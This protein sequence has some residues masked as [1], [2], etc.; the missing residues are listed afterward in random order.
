M[1]P[2]HAAAL[3]LAGLALLTL[4]TAGCT[5]RP[6]SSG[7]PSS[8]TATITPP[9]YATGA[10][11]SGG[12]SLG[13]PGGSSSSSAGKSTAGSARA[14]DLSAIDKQLGAMQSEIDTL[15]MPT[16]SD[17]NGAQSAVY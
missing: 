17:F 12:G 1:T 16:D 4:V 2:R 8:A 6:A 10:G 15:K 5:A 7:M 9:P 11:A 14:V 3:V 13:L